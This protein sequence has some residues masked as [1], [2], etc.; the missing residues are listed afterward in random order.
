MQPRSQ[1]AFLAFLDR[2]KELGCADL[3]DPW[4]GSLAPRRVRCPEGHVGSPTPNNVLSGQGPC[5]YCTGRQSGPR[6]WTYPAFLERLEEIGFDDLGGDWEGMRIHR[7][8]RCP[9]GHATWPRPDN[10]M[11]G[12]GHCVVCIQG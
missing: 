11:R 8:L 4:E 6:P 7:K 9:V 5:R 10:V 12:K 2:L 1:R 3:G